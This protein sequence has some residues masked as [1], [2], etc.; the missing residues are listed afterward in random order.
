[1]FAI[2]KIVACQGLP[3]E[4]RLLS[5]TMGTTYDAVQS[6]DFH[7]PEEVDI[8]CK[9]LL[10]EKARLWPASRRRSE[11]DEPRQIDLEEWLAKA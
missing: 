10:K 1:M 6:T 11:Q 8:F 9:E 7:S 3:N 5:V 4:H 2:R